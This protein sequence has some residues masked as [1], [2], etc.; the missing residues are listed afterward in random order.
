MK[1]LILRL[2]ISGVVVAAV[3]VAVILIFFQKKPLEAAYL[4]LVDA[5]S[6]TGVQTKME[7]YLASDS[8]FADICSDD[9]KLIMKSEFDMIKNE[10]TKLPLVETDKD[11]DSLLEATNNYI[12][13][14]TNTNV[15]IEVFKNYKKKLIDN[16]KD[17]NGGNYP[18]DNS[19]Q[20]VAYHGFK[21]EIR[22]LISEQVNSA[23]LLNQKMLT[24][25]EEGY[26]NKVYNYQL[27]L[28]KTV[29]AYSKYALDMWHKLG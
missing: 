26:Y 29:Y 19:Y 12:E 22:A 20:D 14:V 3:A 25:L 24:C 15:K 27:A 1:K 28:D 5:L 7:S 16:Y 11:Y 10:Y 17:A 13:A 9:Y 18:P 2:L 21:D 23:M 6:E 4:A 8:D